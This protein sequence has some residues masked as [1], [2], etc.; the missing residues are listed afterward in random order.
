MKDWTQIII[1]P[2]DDIKKLKQASYRVHGTWWYELPNQPPMRIKRNGRH[3]LYMV[4]CVDGIQAQVED[5]FY[6]VLLDLHLCRAKIYN[7]PK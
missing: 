2:K 4:P 6:N 1:T 3:W 5:V 7:T